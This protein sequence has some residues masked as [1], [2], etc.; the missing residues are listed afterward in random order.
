MV[1]VSDLDRCSGYEGADRLRV[2]DVMSR[3][4]QVVG[5]DDTVATAAARMQVAGV[6]ALPVVDGTHTLV[7]IITTSDLLLAGGPG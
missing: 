7:G 6:R 4:V 5:P 2:H 3:P 1:C